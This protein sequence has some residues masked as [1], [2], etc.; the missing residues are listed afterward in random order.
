MKRSIVF[1]FF[2]FL[3]GTLS[4]NLKSSNVDPQK[5]FFKLYA[6][7]TEKVHRSKLGHQNH[8]PISLCVIESIYSLDPDN[9]E[10]YTEFWYADGNMINQLD[11]C[12]SDDD[13]VFHIHVELF[14]E[15]TGIFLKN[16]PIHLHW[17]YPIQKN[18]V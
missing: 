13:K 4:N 16:H 14:D 15:N 18:G 17:R 7:Y 2:C 10:R 1:H 12:K 5:T 11:T 8:I 3:W 6:K 9:C